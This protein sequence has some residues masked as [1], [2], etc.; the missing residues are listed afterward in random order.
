M[1]NGLFHQSMSTLAIDWS[2]IWQTT[3]KMKPLQY[4]SMAFTRMGQTKWMAQVLLPSAQF[5]QEEVSL[6]LSFLIQFANRLLAFTYD[7]T[8]Y[9]RLPI[10]KLRLAYMSRLTN[11]EL[12]GITLISVANTSVSSLFNNFICI[13]KQARRPSRPPHCSRSSCT[14]CQPDWSGDRSHLIRLVPYPS[15]I[16]NWVLWV[17]SEREPPRRLWASS[18][19]YS[20]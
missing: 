2:L 19:C 5:L 7:F 6:H 20:N 9:Q 1:V 3:S 16:S 15:S 10:S 13:S 8:V 12:T 17:P 4:I 11:R 18:Q 14:L